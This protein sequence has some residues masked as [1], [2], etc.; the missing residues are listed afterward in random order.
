VVVQRT[1]KRYAL[2][3]TNLDLLANVVQE[4]PGWRRHVPLLLAL[5]SIVALSLALARPHVY[6][7][8]PKREATV[9]LTTD[10]SGSMQATDVQPTRLAAA[11]A[12][13]NE[14][15][16][17]LPDRF[18]IGLVSFSQTSQ[19]LV[20]ATRDRDRVKRAI[21][22]LQSH[23][24]TAMG[25]ALDTSVELLRQWRRQ[26]GQAQRSGANRRQTPVD[27]VVLL[28]DGENTAGAIEPL[29]A[30][31]KARGLRIPVHAVALGTDEGTVS[32]PDSLGGVQT[33]SV[34][35]DR[36]T[37]RQI[38]KNTRGRYFDAPDA[39]ELRSVY[40]GLG[41]RIGYKRERREVTAAFAGAGLG[42]LVLGGGLSLLWFGRI[43]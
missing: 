31:A 15:V 9:M 30:A 6:A 32:V 26:P 3:F 39:G 2:R 24:G 34:P 22:G 20:P 21:N 1:R 27:V 7:D 10:I 33:V 43:P 16:D 4:S 18:K 40:E 23:G 25:E 28:S 41:S 13:A 42:L 11:Q 36:E 14:F 17:S 19:L 38:A 5:L 12:A 35:P 37:L 29:D 8:V